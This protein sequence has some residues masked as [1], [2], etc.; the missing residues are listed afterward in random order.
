MDINEL[1]AKV[2]KGMNI[3]IRKLVESSAEK[4]KSL[5][6]GEIDGSFKAVPAKELLKN[7]PP[8]EA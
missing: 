7:L 8:K 6:I 3:A 4:G 5:I 1:E 2:L